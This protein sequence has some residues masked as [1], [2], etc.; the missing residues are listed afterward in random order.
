MIDFLRSVGAILFV[1]GL[2]IFIHEFGHFLAAKS[3]GVYAP[4]FSIGFGPALIAR[5]WGETEYMIAAVP[6][7]GYVRMAS[8]DDETMAFIEGGRET[9]APDVPGARP[10]FW[11]ENGMAPF[12][13]H[14]VPANRWFE[15]K[16]VPARLVILLAGVTMNVVLGFLIYAGTTAWY[17]RTIL[18]TRVVASVKAPASAPALASAVMAGD[19]ILAIDGAAI[20]SWN[21]VVGAIDSSSGT[22][23]TFRTQRGEAAVPS[24]EPR[25]K[26]RADIADGIS[27]W[28]PPVALGIIAASPAERGGLRSGDTVMAL[29]GTPVRNVQELIAGIHR[30]P[31][32]EIHLEV[33]RGALPVVLAIRP[34]SAREADP[35]TGRQVVVGRIGAQL[36]PRVSHSPVP[37]REAV[38]IGARETWI[39][40]GLVVRSLQSLATGETS[41][42]QLRGPIAIGGFAAEAARSGWETLFGLLALISINVAVF[43]LLPIPVLDGGQIL[44]N[45]AEVVKGSALSIRTRENLIKAG[46]AMILLLLVVVMYNDIPALVHRVFK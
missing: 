13:P 33:R 7:G 44:I 24:G 31:G 2:V 22:V 30:S 15:S 12:G 1:F 14:P 35:E 4:R 3:F 36:G 9:P 32:R 16:P 8:R 39:A 27:P 37:L 26:T 46:L 38:V 45:L 11:S 6:L 29:D 18:P 17:G 20:G 43:N 42:R 25:G 34:D 28:A 40:A 23:L 5:K 19:T 41:L 10:R 21:D